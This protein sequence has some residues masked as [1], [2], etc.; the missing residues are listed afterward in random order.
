M[1]NLKTVRPRILTAIALILLLGV[2]AFGYAAANT[3]PATGAGDGTGVVSGYTISAITYVLTAA[4]PTT[5]DTVSFIVTPVVTSPVTPA[6]TQ[7]RISVAG[8]TWTGDGDCV[9]TV[10]PTWVC[11]F[12]P[13]PTVESIVK[14]QVVATS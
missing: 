8:T 11:T 9:A 2:V 14:L 1:F 4:D 6:A 13:K 3:V 10:P 7:V 12:V 5:V